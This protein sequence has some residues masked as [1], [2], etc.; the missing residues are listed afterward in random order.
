M[1]GGMQAGGMMGGGMMSMMRPADPRMMQMKGEM[2]KAMGDVMMKYG[3][4]PEKPE[5]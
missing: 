4:T 2:M 3:K 5:R 1:M